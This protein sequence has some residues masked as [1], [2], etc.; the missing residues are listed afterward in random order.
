VTAPEWA[1]AGPDSWRASA[2]TSSGLAVLTVRR[3]A[4]TGEWTWRIRFSDSREIAAPRPHLTR[5]N[6]QAAAERAAVRDA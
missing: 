5:G 3:L 2:E 1:Q 4:S 6:A